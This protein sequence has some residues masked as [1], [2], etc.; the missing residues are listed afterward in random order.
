[1]GMD[2][3]MPFVSVGICYSIP[4]ALDCLHVYNKTVVENVCI[5]LDP[6][7]KFDKQIN[8]VVKSCFFKLRLIAKMKPL[9]SF[10]DLE[11]VIHTF[12]FSHLDYCNSLYVRVSQK[13]LAR[14]QSVQ[15]SAAR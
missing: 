4:V 5:L 1:M 13:T 12:I 11:S 10:S 14:L 3:P 15:N 9:L 6:D 2:N 8:S 7:F